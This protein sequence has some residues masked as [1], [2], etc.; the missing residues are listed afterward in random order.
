MH[1]CSPYRTSYPPSPTYEVSLTLPDRRVVKVCDSLLE[2]YGYAYVYQYIPEEQ[3]EV[4]I[5][6]LGPSQYSG[7][8]CLSLVRFHEI[9][10]KGTWREYT[11]ANALNRLY[12]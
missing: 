12:G 3:A 6:E 1:S 9:C 10:R 2:A 4:M 5:V 11:Y 8:G 7:Y